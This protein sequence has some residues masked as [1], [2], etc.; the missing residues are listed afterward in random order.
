MKSND[1][2]ELKLRNLLMLNFMYVVIPSLAIPIIS[3]VLDFYLFPSSEILYPFTIMV[4]IFMVIK[5][6]F[7]IKR[8]RLILD[9]IYGTFLVILC[10]YTYY[11]LH[12][13]SDMLSR[14][15]SLLRA[16]GFND[17][18]QILV[19]AILALNVHDMVSSKTKNSNVDS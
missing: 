17:L 15:E 5:F 16:V 4:S 18:M 9:L 2:L 6:H 12:P 19:S 7:E 1:N 11:G 14:N 10:G 13:T 3:L 8:Y